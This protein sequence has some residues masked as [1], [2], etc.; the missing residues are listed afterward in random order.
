VAVSL[1][2]LRSSTTDDAAVSLDAALVALTGRIRIRE[3]NSRT[4]EDIVTEIWTDV[5]GRT[6][7]DGDGGEGKVS[8]PTRGTTSR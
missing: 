5:F 4:A 3:G 2:S 1:A 7:A 6:D 8:A